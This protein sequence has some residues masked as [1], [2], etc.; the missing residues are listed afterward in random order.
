MAVLLL[1][2]LLLPLLAAYAD[3]HDQ[4]E[5]GSQIAELIYVGIFSES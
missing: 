1:L 4:T 2:L 3:L 5:A